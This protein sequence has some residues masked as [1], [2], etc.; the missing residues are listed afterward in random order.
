MVVLLTVLENTELFLQSNI[1]LVYENNLLFSKDL[2]EHSEAF[3]KKNNFLYY[4]HY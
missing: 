1:C 4:I 3:A 2:Q